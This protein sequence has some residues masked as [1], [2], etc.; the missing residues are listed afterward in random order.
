MTSTLS[1]LSRDLGDHVGLYAWADWLDEQG[2]EELARERRALAGLVERKPALGSSLMSVKS[3]GAL[4]ED[5]RWLLTIRGK[6]RENPSY[7]RCVATFK[8]TGVFT[9]GR[10]LLFFLSAKEKFAILARKAG[11][12][13]PLPIGDL[14]MEPGTRVSPELTDGSAVC[15]H[16]EGQTIWAGAQYYGLVTRRHPMAVWYITKAQPWTLVA[17]EGGLVVAL[18]ASCVS[19]N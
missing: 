12:A 2:E 6:K 8:K 17:L 3:L 18:L 7:P 4:L 5:N 16:G 10:I 1:V 15:L 19:K 9:D 11:E 13:R 14:N